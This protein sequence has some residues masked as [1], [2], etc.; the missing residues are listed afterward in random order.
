MKFH[1]RPQNPLVES[2]WAQVA[3]GSDF[4]T[5]FTQQQCQQWRQELTLHINISHPVNN[6]GRILTIMINLLTVTLVPEQRCII[7]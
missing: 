2:M 6:S 5:L 7:E 1:D 4:E 3:K